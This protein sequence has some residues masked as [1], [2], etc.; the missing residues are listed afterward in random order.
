MALSDE[1]AFRIV[2]RLT[3][4]EHVVGLLFREHA[5]AGGKTA[6]DV[7][8]YAE[9]VKQFFETKLP[10][11]LAEMHINAAVDRLFQQMAADIGNL[12]SQ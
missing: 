6:D 8:R 2:A 4:V 7:T 11:G 9:T 10:T 12:G 5:I 1:D 3:V